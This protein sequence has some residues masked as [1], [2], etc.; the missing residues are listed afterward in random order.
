M[1]HMT[2]EPWECCNVYIFIHLNHTACKHCS[3]SSY[4][5]TQTQSNSYSRVRGQEVLP[6][7]RASAILLRQLLHW[8]L[9]HHSF[10]EGNQGVSLE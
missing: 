10:T 2:P 6:L 5:I 4:K 9:T 7:R 8:I 1:N 3:E